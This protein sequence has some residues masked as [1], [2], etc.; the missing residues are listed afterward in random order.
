VS[1]ARVNN[2]R[3]QGVHRLNDGRAW[4]N[5]QL[6][7]DDPLAL[8]EIQRDYPDFSGRCI[9]QRNG[10][11]IGVYNFAYVR[12]NRAQDLPQVQ[13]RGDSGRQIQEQLKP[14]ML[15]LKLRF[16]AH[17]RMKDVTDWLGERFQPRRYIHLIAPTHG[18]TETAPALSRFGAGLSRLLESLYD[19]ILLKFLT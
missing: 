6:F 14:L 15:T 17:G 4:R 11:G 5:E 2:H 8:R 9:G 7:L 3:F 12:C 10:Y 1:F 19:E 13:T 18:P 16:C